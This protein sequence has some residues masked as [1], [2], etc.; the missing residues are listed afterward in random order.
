MK[1]GLRLCFIIVMRSALSLAGCIAGFAQKGQS[2][3]DPVPVGVAITTEIQCGTQAGS[4]EPYDAS[5][6]VVQVLRG[7]EAWKLIKAASS[8]NKEP[9]A[10]YEYILARIS[11]TMKARGAPG[12]KSFELGRPMQF[13]ALSSDGREYLPPS[14]TSPKPELARIIRADEQAE[15]WIVF[16]V[17]KE[18]KQPVMVFDPSSGGAMLR[19]KAVFFK[20]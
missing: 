6:K 18:E 15:G 12:D 17:E 9:Q 10:G 5:I 11:F 8:A 16:M 7:D 4:L 13:V 1:A 20:L 3:M 2:P 14:V 19:G